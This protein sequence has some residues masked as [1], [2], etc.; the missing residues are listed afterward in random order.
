MKLSVLR[1]CNALSIMHLAKNGG[2]YYVSAC[3]GCFM[4]VFSMSSFS[5]FHSP[6]LYGKCSKIRYGY[7]YDTKN[8]FCFAGLFFRSFVDRSNLLIFLMR[9]IIMC[10]HTSCK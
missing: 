7:P 1:S 8:S 3:E 4:W 10:A 9:I 6:F 2:G 5:S